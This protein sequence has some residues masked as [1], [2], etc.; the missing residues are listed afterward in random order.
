M[1]NYIRISINKMLKLLKDISSGGVICPVKTINS[2]TSKIALLFNHEI[3]SF[4]THFIL[5]KNLLI[6]K[7]INASF[8]YE[9]LYR[10]YLEKIFSIFFKIIVQKTENNKKIVHC[11]RVPEKFPNY[12]LYLETKKIM[13]E[14]FEEENKR[15]KTNEI[16]KNIFILDEL[17]NSDDESESSDSTVNDEEEHNYPLKNSNNIKNN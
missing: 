9:I 6:E 13:D 4:N 16:K 5:T 11:V 14:F 8:S 1:R 7:D 12:R 15:F 17:L 10:S 3:T 2:N